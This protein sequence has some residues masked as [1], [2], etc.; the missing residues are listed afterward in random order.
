MLRSTYVAMGHASLTIG[1]IG[2]FVPLLPKTIR[3]R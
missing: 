2:T 1:C 3:H